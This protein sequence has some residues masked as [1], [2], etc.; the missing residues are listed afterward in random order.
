MGVRKSRDMENVL[1]RSSRRRKLP[2][3]G[4]DGGNSE[5][6]INPKLQELP[7]PHPLRRGCKG[8][9]W[10]QGGGNALEQVRDTLEWDEERCQGWGSA[11]H[12]PPR[13]KFSS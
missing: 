3:K 1:T 10:S 9:G 4:R 6:K 7:L 11:S 8:Q 12:I 5:I 2:E 13:E